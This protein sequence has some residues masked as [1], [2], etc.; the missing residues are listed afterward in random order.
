MRACVLLLASCGLAFATV[1]GCQDAWSRDRLGMKGQDGLIEPANVESEPQPNILPKTYI[2]AGRLAESRGDLLLA[3]SMYRKATG[4]DHDDAN[5]YNR[6]GLVLDRLGQFQSADA[7]L[8]TAVDLAPEKAYLR[9][10]LAYNYILQ[11]RWKEAEEELRRALEC[12]PSFARARINLGFVLGRTG[13]YDQAMRE[14]LRVLPPASAHYNL[15]LMYEINRRYRLAR[16]SFAQALSLDPRMASAQ[17]GLQRVEVEAALAEDPEDPA[18]VA[19]SE[20]AQTPVPEIDRSVEA[21]P[22]TTVLTEPLPAP[23]VIEPQ[24]TP[25]PVTARVEEE[26]PVRVS[27]PVEETRPVPER[28]PAAPS[29]PWADTFETPRPSRSVEPTGTPSL[30]TAPTPPSPDQSDRRPSASKPLES[31]HPLAG[32]IEAGKSQLALVNVVAK[33]AGKAASWWS[34]EQAQ[35]IR[36]RLAD[37][38]TSSPEDTVMAA[39]S[40]PSEPIGPPLVSTPAPARVEAKTPAPAVEPAEENRQALV[41][42]TSQIA[43]KVASWWSGEPVQQV[44]RRLADRLSPEPVGPPPLALVKALPLVLP[45]AKQPELEAPPDQRLSESGPQPPPSKTDRMDWAR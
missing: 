45:E 42:L 12:Q 32:L 1:A 16:A 44:R 40:P 11:R 17:K 35:Q 34:G 36:R 10:N 41:N 33:V 20:P 19:Q 38:F 28:V 5:A 14:F 43:G 25:P 8:Q 24:P 29:K 15:G 37:Q 23:E 21:E 4:L 31:D 7:A 9:N 18:R 27:P 13:E 3:V 6:L 2:A 30:Q 39:P 22:A 26:T